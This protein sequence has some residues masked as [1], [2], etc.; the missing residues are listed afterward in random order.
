M[1][2][3]RGAIAKMGLW[4]TEQMG[5]KP[6]KNDKGNKKLSG[7]VQQLVTVAAYTMDGFIPWCE[8][9][10]RQ[11]DRSGRSVS[12][13]SMFCAFFFCDSLENN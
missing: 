2:L 7:Y 3:S 13:F 9:R 11:F 1:I 5:L 12:A 6:Q 4:Y 10:M 8:E